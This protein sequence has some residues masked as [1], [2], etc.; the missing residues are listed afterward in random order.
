MKIKP[1][2]TQAYMNTVSP[3]IVE[4]ALDLLQSNVPY[5]LSGVDGRRGR[6]WEEGRVW[7]LG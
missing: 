2:H 6:T 4:K 5:T 3:D 1:Q 7:E